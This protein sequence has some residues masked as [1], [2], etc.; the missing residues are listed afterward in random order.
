MITL[1][2]LFGQL[3]ERTVAPRPAR[4][5]QHEQPRSVALGERGLRDQLFGQFVVEF[6]NQH[7]KK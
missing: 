7:D 1:A 2:Q 3:R 5:I 6:G 4:A